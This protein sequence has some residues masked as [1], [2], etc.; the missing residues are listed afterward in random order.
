MEACNGGRKQRCPRCGLQGSWHVTAKE[1]APKRLNGHAAYRRPKRFTNAVAT[2]LA[3]RRASA[4]AAAAAATTASVSATAAFPVFPSTATGTRLFF[5]A[6]VA[7]KARQGRG[8][9]VA[10]SRHERCRTRPDNSSTAGRCECTVC[11]FGAS[12]IV[13]GAKG[14]ELHNNLLHLFSHRRKPVDDGT[15]FFFQT[16]EEA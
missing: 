11:I 7:A 13:A 5:V 10:G 15:S 14:L 6:A 2:F 1:E 9:G 3:R 12:E 4:A 8:G 16:P